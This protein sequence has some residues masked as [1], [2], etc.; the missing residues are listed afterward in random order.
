MATLHRIEIINPSHLSIKSGHYESTENEGI[1]E[2]MM[3]LAAWSV[4]IWANIS[5]AILSWC[6]KI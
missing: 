3:S 2:D 1:H 5:L 6:P 4:D